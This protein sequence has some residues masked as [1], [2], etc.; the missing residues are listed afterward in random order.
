LKEILRISIIILSILAIN[1]CKKDKPS[2]PTIIT[3][4][5]TEIFTTSA[6]SGGVVTNEGGSPVASRGVC[7]N[8]ST[9]PTI[10]NSFTINGD[11]LGAFISNI[12]KL[13]PNTT[14]YVRAYALNSVGTA[15]GN[16]Q[17]FTTDINTVTDNDGNVYNTIKLGTQVW[18]EENLKTTKYNDGTSIPLI[19][20]N[21]QWSNLTTDAFCWY[22]NDAAT[23]K[24]SY[25]ALYNWYS[26]NTGKLCPTG[27]RVPSDSEWGT[28]TNYLGGFDVAGGK[29]KEVGTPHWTSPN[30]G[31]T[32]ESGFTS[33]PA[34]QR[35]TDGT[36]SDLGIAAGWW[37]STPYNS[38][39]P[40][41]YSNYYSNAMENHGNGTMNNVGLSIRCIKN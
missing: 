7:W 11:G 32:N 24:V 27:W 22:N 41:Y 12:T 4:E 10:T 28:M 31:A 15:Y 13:L 17:S 18:M 37:T 5:V 19:T 21:V 9:N 34:G 29:M 16:E 2:L 14:Y 6:Q 3:T 39:K 8:T 26:V 25:G 1:S 35:T 40:W 23:Y 33:L 30:T 20:N 38:D 36:F